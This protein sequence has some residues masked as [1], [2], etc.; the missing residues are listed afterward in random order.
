MVRNSL[1]SLESG[2]VMDPLFDLLAGGGFPEPRTFQNL[3]MKTDVKDLGASYQMEI[4]VP[5]V[6]KKDIGVAYDEGYLTVT[7]KQDREVNDKDK[8][9]NYVHRERFSGV[10]S[11]SYY[12]GT[13]DEK[14]IKANYA[15]GVLSLT[16]PKEAENKK[17]VEHQIPVL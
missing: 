8:K 1:A 3:D 17:A 10:A 14:A 4:E 13:I 12:V 16:F 2:F 5:G 15:D 11:R 6:N 9:G 7:V